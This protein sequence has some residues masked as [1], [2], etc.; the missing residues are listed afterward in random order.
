VT[1]KPPFDVQ[2]V[3]KCCA[4][5]ER[6]EGGVVLRIKGKITQ[7]RGGLVDFAGISPSML[8][9]DPVPRKKTPPHYSK[10]RSRCPENSDLGWILGFN[11]HFTSGTGSS[12]SEKGE[13]DHAEGKE[14]SPRDTFHGEVTQ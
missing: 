9:K 6:G 11:S 13:E 7:K 12:R 14:I 5:K 8:V 3:S 4:P 2:G 1:T 10:S